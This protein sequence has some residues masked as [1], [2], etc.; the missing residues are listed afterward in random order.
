MGCLSCSMDNRL[1]GIPPYLLVGGCALSGVF[2]IPSGAVVSS[3]Y[4][5]SSHSEAD[6]SEVAVSH[7]PASAFSTRPFV[8][9]FHAG[10]CFSPRG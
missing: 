5:S 7:L 9:P 6:G 4:S 10:K 1:T 8:L 2:H 3:G